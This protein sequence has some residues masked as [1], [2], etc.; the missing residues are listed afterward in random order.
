MHEAMFYR[1]VDLDHLQCFLCAHHCRIKTG[2][3]GICG[4][5]ENQAGRLVS[6]NY[7]RLISENIDPIEKKPIF[8]MLPGSLSYSIATVG[9]N[10]RCRH[11]QNFEISQYPRRHAG[12][13]P[14]SIRSPEE[15]VAG[16]IQTGCRTISYT[17]VEPTIFY[18]FALDCARLA[19]E[20]GLGN[21]FVSNGYTSADA[22]RALAPFLD[23]NN[24]DLKAFT[25]RFYKEVCGAKLQPVLDT[26]QLMH[27]LGVW[28]EVT[29]LVI[30]GW[31][32][33]DEEL[34]DIARFIKG[35]SQD[36]P[37]H[38]TRFWPTFEMTDRPPTPP[39]SLLR[40]REIG[41][42]EGLRY[43]YVGNIPGDP[44]ENTHCPGCGNL[45]IERVG[46]RIAQNHLTETGCCSWCAMPI[47]GIF[48]EPSD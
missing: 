45:L 1:S 22:T 29:T 25:E 3:R 21:I 11:C 28:V 36:M 7:G 23:A 39:A 2:G 12:A 37:W 20:R 24:I 9:C 10:F 5:R 38:V 17:Y 19:K 26:I 18:E 47:A 15:V 8:H 48:H 35:I 31:N 44:G 16:A 6:R 27:Q 33:S 42:G 13:I 32:D 14:G 34:R 30:P 43:V 40:A 4:V 46:Y 41:L